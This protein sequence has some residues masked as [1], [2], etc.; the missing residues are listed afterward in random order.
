RFRSRVG[1]ANV[2]FVRANLFRPPVA[3]GSVDVGLSSGVLH[4]TADPAGGFRALVDAVRPGGLVVVGLYSVTG[5]LLLPTLRSRH[6]K[7]TTRRGQAWYHD[8]HLHPHETRHFVHEV[9]GWMDTAGVRFVRAFPDISFGG[10]DV[11]GAAW[12]HWAKQLSWLGRAAD[13][14]LF[15]LVGRKE[16]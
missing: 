1:L 7:D 16:A 15:V 10:P 2:R 14:G 11:R 4:H 8:Q 9:L 13:G 12:E 6:A 5:R 3:P